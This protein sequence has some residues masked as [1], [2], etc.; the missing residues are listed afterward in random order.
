[1]K[2]GRTDPLLPCVATNSYLISTGSYKIPNIINQHPVSV[3]GVDQ[4]PE[5]SARNDNGW[6]SKERIFYT[7]FPNF[8]LSV[9]FQFSDISHSSALL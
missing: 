3:R 7:E 1:M 9:Y 4:W 6:N 8:T 2:H 5:Y